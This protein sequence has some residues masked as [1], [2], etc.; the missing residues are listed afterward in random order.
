MTVF[1]HIHLLVS[2]GNSQILFF[3][4]W[5][6]SQIIAATL[7]DAAGECYDKIGRMIGLSYPAGVFLSKIAKLEYANLLDLPIGM[8]KN[9]DLNYSFSGL[10]TAVRYLIKN[11]SNNLINYEKKLTDEEINLLIACN[12]IE[13]S[14]NLNEKLQLIYKI[15]VSTESAI[16][17]QLINKLEL[18]INIHKPLTLGLSGGVSASPLLRQEVKKIAE[19]YKLEQVFIPN[20]KLTGDNAVMIGLAGIANL[21]YD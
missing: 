5:K 16:I 8:S 12:S 20:I 1:P 4:S 7:D 18:A 10:K 6:Q 17:K 2:G 3:Q 11:R 14:Y 21:Y 19:K 9:K 13:E 15:C